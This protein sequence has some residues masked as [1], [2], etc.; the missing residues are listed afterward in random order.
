MARMY[1]TR[2]DVVTTFATDALLTAS[3]ATSYTTG[4]YFYSIASGAYRWLKDTS[5]YN[6]STDLLADNEE[7]F[8]QKVTDVG[9]IEVFGS[10]IFGNSSDDSVRFNGKLVGQIYRNE[11]GVDAKS[12]KLHNHDTTATTNNE[13]KYETINTSGANYGT[14]NEC[15]I[16]ATGTATLRAQTNVAVVEAL[17]GDGVAITVTDTTLI[18]SYAQA[19]ADGTIAGNSFVSSSYA[20]V[21]ASVA[22]T[23]NHL[24]ALWLDTH[25]ANV[26]AGSYQLLYMTENGA[27][28]LDQVMYLRTPGAVAFAEFDTC[29]AMVSSGAQTGGT[30]KKIRV[31]VDGVEHFWNVYT[32]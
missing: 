11:T 20:I 19:R 18:A 3:S 2:N 1:F 29:N 17:D 23:V 25:M 16:A 27:T 22:M 8:Y 28:A 13:F 30:A 14:W 9:H 15:H 10:A 21:G 6:A 31:T 26:V 4:D 12:L 7:S 5:L 32:G 24:N